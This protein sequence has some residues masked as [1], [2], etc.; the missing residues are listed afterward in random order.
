V[1]R[2]SLR[3]RQRQERERAVLKT[4]F[5]LFTAHGY[6]ATTMDDVARE[7]GISKATLYQ[8]V[9]SKEE[10]AVSVIVGILQ[11]LEALIRGLDPGLPATVQLGQAFRWLVVKRHAIQ[12]ATASQASGGL[13]NDLRPILWSNP[14][15]QEQKV[16]V[17]CAF[18]A[19]VERGQAEGTIDGTL[20]SRIIVQAVLSLVR[21]FDYAELLADT[22]VS[23]EELA[24]AL[25]TILWHGIRPGT[26]PG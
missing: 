9:P 11:Q 4:A 12:S 1:K 6:A 21:D 18:S 17:I 14:R 2:P 13:F 7:V 10:L 22:S 15:F 24:D 3:E 23:G 25:L 26:P 8:Q 16:K 20:P 19:V 5:E